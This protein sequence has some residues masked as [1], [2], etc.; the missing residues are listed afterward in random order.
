M[1]EVQCDDCGWRDSAG[2]VDV[3]S[4]RDRCPFC[5]SCAIYARRGDAQAD[6]AGEKM[7]KQVGILADLVFYKPDGSDTK[8]YDL[9]QFNEAIIDLAV[10]H[11][12]E[13]GGIMKLVFDDDEKASS[14]E[15][16][17]DK[18]ASVR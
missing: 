3:A 10:A 1:S 6:D 12:L 7:D 13:C 15:Q 4:G 11:G 2:K 16:K 9:K 8:M 5:N 18:S 17:N 14:Q